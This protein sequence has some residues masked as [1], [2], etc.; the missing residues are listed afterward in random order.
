MLIDFS[1]KLLWLNLLQIPLSPFLWNVIGRTQY[2]TK[3]LT[4]YFKGNKLHACYAIFVWVFTQSLIRDFVYGL[5]ILNQPQVGFM[6]SL[7]FKLAGV[8]SNLIGWTFTLSSMYR[9]GITGLFF[10]QHF[11]FSQIP[12]ITT[13]TGTYLGDYCGILMKERVKGFPYNVSFHFLIVK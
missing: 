5:V 10:S 11:F 8:I 2:Q 9:L 12:I 13:I 6:S 1:Q 3:F 7:P 4:N